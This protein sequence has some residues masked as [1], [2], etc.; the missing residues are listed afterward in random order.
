MLLIDIEKQVKPLSRAEKWQLIKD[1][2]NMLMQE[3][4]DELQQL[5]Q[6]ESPYPLFTPVGLEE[7]AAKLQQYLHEGKL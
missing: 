4:L 1:V 3:E 7:G 5:S 2:Q 6:S